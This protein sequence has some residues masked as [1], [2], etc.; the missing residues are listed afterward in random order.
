MIDF[1]LFLHSEDTETQK[2]QDQDEE[3]S[4]RGVRGLA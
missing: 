4:G 2:G 1:N 3:A